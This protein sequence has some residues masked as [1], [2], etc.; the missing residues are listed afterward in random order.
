MSPEWVAIYITIIGLVG[1]AINVWIALVI[2][3]A[4]LG[5]KLW[6]RDEFV[7]KEEHSDSLAP[8]REA[9]QLHMTQRRLAHER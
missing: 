3:N 8:L 2:K 6:C 4:I 7:T 1:T 5:L 9:V